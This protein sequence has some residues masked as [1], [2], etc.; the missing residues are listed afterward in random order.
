MNLF[1]KQ[2]N[3]M[4]QEKLE[5]IKNKI[6]KSRHKQIGNIRFSEDIYK[7][8]CEISE[9]LGITKQWFIQQVVTDFIIE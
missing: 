9:E 2:I 1:G 4:R 3:N 6:H 8:I 7:K 5:K